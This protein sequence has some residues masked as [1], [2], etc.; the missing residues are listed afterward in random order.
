MTDTTFN[1]ANPDFKFVLGSQSPR[2]KYILEQI[3]VYPDV[4]QPADIDETPHKNEK[5][6]PYVERMAIEKL[7]AL[8]PEFQKDEHTF[9]ITGDTIVKAGQ[10]ILGKS[11]TADEARDM[12]KFLSG[13]SHEVV[14]SVALYS[15]LTQKTTHK[16]SVSRVKM[17]RLSHKDIE[18]Y[19]TLK[20]WEGCAGSYQ[21]HGYGGAFVQKVSGSYTGI[22]GFPVS[23]IRNMLLGA[24]Y[25]Q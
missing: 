13:R 20:Q 24:G 21:I 3:Q 11:D 22:M 14:S 2:R 4:I 19:I 8:I 6:L 25:I 10:R 15:P 5:P 9:I 12:L 1:L 23:V 18:D 7:E 16:Q 17:K